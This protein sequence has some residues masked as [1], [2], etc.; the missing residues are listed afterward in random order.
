MS[1]KMKLN[2]PAILSFKRDESAETEAKQDMLDTAGLTVLYHGNPTVI[3]KRYGV[4]GGRRVAGGY[5]YPNGTR[6]YTDA[7]KY[8]AFDLIIIPAYTLEPNPA[9]RDRLMSMLTTSYPR[10]GMI[11]MGVEYNTSMRIYLNTEAME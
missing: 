4:P 1:F 11:V 5:E 3:E 10:L 6:I 7:S 2:R 9:L 8:S